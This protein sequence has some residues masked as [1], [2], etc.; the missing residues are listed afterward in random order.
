[1]FIFGVTGP[2]VLNQRRDATEFQRVLQILT[3]SKCV[4]GCPMKIF[5]VL[6]KPFTRRELLKLKSQRVIWRSD[7]ERWT[8]DDS[9]H[10]R[11]KR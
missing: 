5:H 9:G 1:M 8:L 11:N 4:H 10:L 6:N 2:T 7:D 3:V